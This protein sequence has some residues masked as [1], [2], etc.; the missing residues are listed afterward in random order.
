MATTNTL[1]FFAN[2][3]LLQVFDGTLSGQ[4]SFP[5]DVPQSCTR[6]GC[7]ALQVAL[8][9]RFSGST[10]S[11]TAGGG[12]G[13]DCDLTL[14]LFAFKSGTY[15]TAGG[16]VTVTAGTQYPYHYC[17]SGS[18]LTYAGAQQNPADRHVTYVLQQLP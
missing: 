1:Q 6:L 2:G 18:T 11:C 9:Q 12:G 13:C 16:V 14:K 7:Q 8:E 15:T 17:V 3:N 5:P 4:A 10:V